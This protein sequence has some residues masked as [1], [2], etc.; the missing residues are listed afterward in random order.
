[1][2]QGNEVRVVD[3]AQA[4]DPARQLRVA[5]LPA[6]DGWVGE[7]S[8]RVGAGEDECQLLVI[9]AEQRKGLEKRADILARNERS[10]VQEV[11]LP[12]P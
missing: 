4:K 5:G 12:D 8:R 2:R 10:D 3:V 11:P 1:M 9:S 6:R 7:P